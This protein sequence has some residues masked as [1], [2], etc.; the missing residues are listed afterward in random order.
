MPITFDAIVRGGAY[1][2]P[3]LAKRWGYK[4][5]SAI[6]KGIVT[7]AN[8]DK[9]VLFVTKEKQKA[10]VQYADSFDGEVLHMEG[11]KNHRADTGLMNAAKQG[12]EVHL[13]FRKRH[14]SPFIYYGQVRLTDHKVLSDTP[15]KFTFRTISPEEETMAENLE[16][17]KNA[18]EIFEADEEGGKRIRQHV[19]YERSSRNRARA[20]QIHGTIC[21]AC[22]FDFDRVYGA[23][24]ARHY[25][26]VHHTRSIGAGVT[27]PNPETDL[28]P[29]CSNCHSMAH[30]KAGQILSI[31]EIVALIQKARE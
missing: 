16:T 15:S 4:A 12:K 10:F 23:E 13:F 17:E 20:I 21:S 18:H 27:V 26:E 5:H 6:S 2:R 9:I 1:D 28:V 22:G 31:E 7:P 30:R 3:E 14:H 25:I 19:L 29:L 8:G 11:E 24:Y